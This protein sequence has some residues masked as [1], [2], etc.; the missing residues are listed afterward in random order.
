[1]NN[2][3]SIKRLI[4][5]IAQSGMDQLPI[6]VA[7]VTRVDKDKATIDA[8][9]I[10][11]GQPQIFDVRLMA[12]IDDYVVGI[13]TYPVLQS[14]VL[15]VPIEN[16]NTAYY[17]LATSE[18]EE[19]LLVM[20]NTTTVKLNSDLCSIDCPQIVFNGGGIGGMVKLP[21][22]VEALSNI[23]AYCNALRT[24]L[25]TTLPVSGD[26][27]AAIKAAVVAAIGSLP[28]AD[29]GSLGNEKIVQ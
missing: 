21:S 3:A 11:Q 6:V 1:M 17:L 24:A 12:G 22:L 20:G 9:P 10:V 28:L 18:V 25:T 29:I 23:N 2:N 26:G 4:R 16:D 27:G 15:L 14:T 19:V 13:V 5:E 8:M 7:R